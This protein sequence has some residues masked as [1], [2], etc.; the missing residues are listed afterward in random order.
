MKRKNDAGFTL[1]ELM[2][3]ITILG[4]LAS[5]TSVAVLNHLKTAR[6]ESSKTSMRAIKQ[7]IQMYY[8]KKTR[9]PADLK[10]LCGPEGDEDRFLESEEPP[11][12][13]WNNDFIYSPRD[14]KNYDL[15][16][17]GSDGVEGGDGDAKDITLADLNKRTEEEKE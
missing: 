14:K 13:G 1:I 9:I 7:G 11:K 3:V 6:I 4:L 5:I 12:D 2:V 16:C 8:M 15:I 10:D 17:L